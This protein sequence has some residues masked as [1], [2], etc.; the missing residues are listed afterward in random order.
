MANDDKELLYAVSYNQNAELSVTGAYLIDP[1]YLNR[2]AGTLQAEDSPRRKA[3]PR[4]DYG[5]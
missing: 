1:R 2:V 5:V 4:R 3:I